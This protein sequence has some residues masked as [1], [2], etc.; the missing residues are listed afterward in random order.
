MSILDIELDELAQEREILKAKEKELKKQID[1][2]NNA[3]IE[4]LGREEDYKTDNF[5]FVHKIIITP[6]H[7]VKE[8]ISQ[9]LKVYN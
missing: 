2:I 7:M 4:K 8:T 6:A 9:P 5:H 1:K 3:I